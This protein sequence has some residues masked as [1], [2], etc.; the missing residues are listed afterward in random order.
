MNID[1]SRKTTASE[2]KRLFKYLDRADERKK[3]QT[4]VIV[5]VLFS[6]SLL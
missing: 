2:H 4:R 3:D 5:A 1:A 6:M